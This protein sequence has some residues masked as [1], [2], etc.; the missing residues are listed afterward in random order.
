M[1]IGVNGRV[2]VDIIGVQNGVLSGAQPPESAS[3]L[4]ATGQR[5][6]VQTVH[7]QSSHTAHYFLF[8]SLFI[9]SSVSGG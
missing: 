9:L 5:S 2:W 8:F 3:D 4:S 1:N 7:P 6:T